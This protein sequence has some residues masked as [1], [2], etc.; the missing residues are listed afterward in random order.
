MCSAI[1]HRNHNS[2]KIPEAAQNFGAGIDDDDDE[3][4]LSVINT[5]REQS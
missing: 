1:K 4:I 3:K 2:V 5:V